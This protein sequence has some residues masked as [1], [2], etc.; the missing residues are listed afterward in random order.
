MEMKPTDT[1][2]ILSRLNDIEKN[3]S[4]LREYLTKYPE[5]SFYKI[6]KK[7]YDN[8]D[9]NDIY[10]ESLGLVVTLDKIVEL[11]KKIEDVKEIF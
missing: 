3:I 9:Y 6:A 11:I 10:K 4:I 2:V 5:I 1:V 8:H 7:V